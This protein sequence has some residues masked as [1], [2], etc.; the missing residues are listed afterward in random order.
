VVTAAD[1]RETEHQSEL[2]KFHGCAVRA[3]A[4]ESEYRGRLI[5][6]KAQISGWT[7]RPENQL[8]KNHLEHLFATRSA[9]IVGLSAQDANI[10]TIWHQAS[11]NL[12]RAW[13]SSPPG[14][15]FAEQSLHHHHK[16]VLRVTYGDSYP[17]KV[18]AVEESALLGAF[19]K[20]ALVALVVFTLTEKLCALIAGSAGSLLPDSELEH[21]REGVR[22][23]RRPLGELADAN[24]RWFIDA[25]VSGV[26]LALLAFRSG[27]VPDP[28]SITYQPISVAPVPTAL[29]NP[30]FPAA[31]LGRFAMVVGLLGR[32]MSEGL[33]T[34]AM[35]TPGDPT[36]GVVRVTTAR[37]TAR[38]FVVADARSLSQLEVDGV[39]DLADD[40]TV[41]VQAE[42][43]QSLN[44]R[45]PR[46]RYGRTG[47]SGA[48]YVD[49]E[50]LC[51]TVSTSDELYEAFRL[52]GA[53]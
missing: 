46:P 20:P 14:V 17:A 24:L 51:A 18:D 48:R 16:H 19:A 49:F 36:G 29:A 26:A 1:F 15:V 41:V 31:K 52:E 30:D 25:V 2:V 9:F 45:S 40:E 11:Q 35:G 38:F 12:V 27:R 53:L 10:H 44:T 50:Q 22:S 21:L 39:V 33:W 13:P 8:M 5:A 3:A 32:G 42:A 7:T 23:L 4:D 47:A 43:T 34:L 37:E 28:G 6:R